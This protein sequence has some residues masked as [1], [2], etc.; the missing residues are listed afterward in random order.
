[1]EAQSLHIKALIAYTISLS[2]E[3]DFVPS[4]ISTA[5]V[6]MKASS[7]QIFPITRSL[8]MNA[9]RLDPTNHRAWSNLALIC[10][11]NGSL[12]QAV[13]FFQAAYELQS[14]APIQSFL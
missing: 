3:P 12:Q 8:L 7:S 9:L 5:E 11:K 13:D 14:T 6:M 4:I 1:L 2:I 10:K